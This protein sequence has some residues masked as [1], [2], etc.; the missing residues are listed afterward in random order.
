M[1]STL[2]GVDV[3]RDPASTPAPAAAG[4]ARFVV[5]VWFWVRRYGPAELACLVT[6][7][8]ASVIAANL[9][10]SP[11]LL[12]AAAILGATVGFY[13]VLITTVLREQLTLMPPQRGRTGRALVRAFG[14]LGAEFGIAEVADTFVLRPA[15][16]M[17]GVVLL[18]DPIAGLLAGKLVADV[19][20][21]V[22]SGVCF[23]ITER[24]GIRMPRL[25][26]GA[27][28]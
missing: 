17:I 7:L 26:V 16:M 11:P 12:A 19:L 24:T 18:R 21:Y 6:M 23:R 15:L 1:S 3:R 4:R 28:R 9:T 27:V 8:A 20:F 14:L 13:G 10:D 2:T 22:V 25:R 5:R